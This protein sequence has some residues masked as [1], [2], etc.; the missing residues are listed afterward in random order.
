VRGEVFVLVDIGSTFTKAAAVTNDG[1]L[2]DHVAMATSHE[3]LAAGAETAVAGLV[4]IDPLDATL[5]ACSSAAGGLR[6]AVLG[7]EPRLTMEAGRRAATS[8]GARVAAVFGGI[9]DERQADELRAGKPDIVLLVGGTDG[10]DRTT[11]LSNARRVRELLPPSVP[12]VLAG[13]LDAAD[14]SA[15][16]LRAGGRVVR[17]APNVLPAV[18][19][20]AVD[21]VQRAIRDVF[22]D[23]VIGRGR[24]PPSSRVAQAILMPTPSAVLAATELLANLAG[25]DPRL[26][27]PVVIDVGGATTD[28]HSVI[29]A[30]SRP[31]AEKAP[32]PELEATRTVEADL[33]M[34][35]SAAALAEAAIEAGHVAAGAEQGLRRAARR[36]VDDRAFLPVDSEGEG[37]DRALARFAVGIALTRHAGELRVGLGEG[38]ATIRCTGRDLRAATCIVATGGVFEA[39]RDPGAIIEQAL[40]DALRRRAVVPENL[41]VFIDHNR[42]LAPTGLLR[43]RDRSAAESLVVGAF[44]DGGIELAA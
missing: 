7:F 30:D 38:G 39:A 9:L 32:V 18:G 1:R 2:L 35:E 13:N 34:R 29:P 25:R 36:R 40:E 28:V 16:E 31:V 41:A 20:I 12:A 14:E 44:K 42:V 27:A 23:H 24:F 43:A 37:V 4:G 6:V 11:I 21:E 15:V 22:V 33:G 19:V 10:G 3:D 8:A 26:R 5:L 17:I